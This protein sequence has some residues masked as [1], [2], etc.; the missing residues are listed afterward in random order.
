MEKNF[1][2]FKND[3][4]EERFTSAKSKKQH[5]YDHTKTK[6]ATQQEIDAYEAAADALALRPV[7]HKIIFGYEVDPESYASHTPHEMRARR[8]CKYNKDTEEYVVYGGLSQEGEPIVISFYH[9]SWQEFQAK[10]YTNY[11]D[12]IP[13]PEYQKY[14]DFRNN[15]KAELVEI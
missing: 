3:G 13:V 10:K 7:D 9:I 12:E 1:I 14:W 5:F 6:L 4:L 15:P 8:F 2:L 11:L